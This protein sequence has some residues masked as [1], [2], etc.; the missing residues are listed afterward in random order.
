MLGCTPDEMKGR[1][2]FD[3]M[4][5][6]GVALCMENLERR[7]AR[8][9]SYNVCYTKLLRGEETEYLFRLILEKVR[10]YG[11]WVNIPIRCDSPVLRRFLEISIGPLS[12]KSVEFRSR[13]IRVESRP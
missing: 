10:T 13:V 8:I 4:D 2:L 5:E 3:F 1:H 7:R 6:K 9:T 12:E 11:K